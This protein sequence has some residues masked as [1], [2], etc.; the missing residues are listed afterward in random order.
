MVGALA[1]AATSVRRALNTTQIGI[2]TTAQ[3]LRITVIFVKVEPSFQG[4]FLS[5]SFFA[6]LA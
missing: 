2:A 1:L 3:G 4:F 5:P 6:L